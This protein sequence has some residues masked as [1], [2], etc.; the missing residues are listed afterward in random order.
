MRV[1]HIKENKLFFSLPDIK[2]NTKGT[3]DDMYYLSMEN[4]ENY[5]K[6]KINL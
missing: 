2:R 1:R 4:F 5:N 3:R 6:E